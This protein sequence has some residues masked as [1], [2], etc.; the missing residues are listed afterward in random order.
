MGFLSLQEPAP[1]PG[2][3]L[4]RTE[5]LLLS[6]GVHALLLLLLGADI[7]SHLP[8]ALAAW[9]A[10]RPSS[11]A[12]L[13]ELAAQAARAQAPTPLEQPKIPLKFAY[14]K[15]PNDVASD[16]NPAARLLSDKN[17]R[18]RQEVPTPPD[19]KK[20]SL[21][22]HSVGD[23]ITREKP[24]PSR[25]EGRDTPEPPPPRPAGGRGG[26]APGAEEPREARAEQRAQAPGTP[27]LASNGPGS[28]RAGTSAAAPS[29]A[30]AAEL[31]APAGEGESAS[32]APRDRLTQALTDL[33]AGEFKFTFNNPAYLKNGSFGTMSFDTQ[34]FPW[35]DYA[36]RL[37]V[38]IRNNWLERVPLAAREGI[39]GN[40]CQRF[41]IAKDGTIEEIINVRRSPVPPFNNAA[42]DAIRASSPLPPLPPDFPHASE[43]VTFCFYYNMYPEEAD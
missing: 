43:G 34:D 7:V 11:E 38:I 10:P 15:I 5:A 8:P 33:K 42:A 40:S 32:T 14:V 4:T 3:R 35:G 23:V 19:A 29:G 1:L 28:V 18:A 41:V 22:P 25:P 36:R 9:L 21:D 26:K 16:K 12:A 30:A 24:D 31:P 39:A 6:L 27:P 37:Y 20:F 13:R 17:R 2:R